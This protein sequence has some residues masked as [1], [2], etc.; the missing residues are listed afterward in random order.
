MQDYFE[1]IKNPID[2]T[3]VSN[4]LSSGEYKSGW[5]VR[6]AHMYTCSNVYSGKVIF[7]LRYCCTILLIHQTDL[8][9]SGT[10]TVQIVPGFTDKMCMEILS[11]F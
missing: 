1:V 4:K 8:T 3:T 11:D 10:C 6:S 9:V 2:L 5:E 7:L